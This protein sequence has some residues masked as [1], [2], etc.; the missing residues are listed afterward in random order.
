MARVFLVLMLLTPSFNDDRLIWQIIDALKEKMVNYS[1]I[2]QR[3]STP[4]PECGRKSGVDSVVDTS[5]GDGSAG[6][7]WLEIVCS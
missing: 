4:T 5:D 6:V 1:E 3:V 7:S 2:H